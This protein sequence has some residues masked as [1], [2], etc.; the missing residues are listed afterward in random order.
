MQTEVVLLNFKR[1]KGK[2]YFINRQGNL[3]EMD[4]V[5]HKKKLVATPGITKEKGFFY[6]LNKKGN[7]ARFRPRNG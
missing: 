3:V 4:T 5:S 6:F 7:I 2:L 1:K